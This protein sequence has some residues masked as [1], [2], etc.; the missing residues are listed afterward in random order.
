MMKTLT[1]SF[2]LR[3]DVIVLRGENGG[4][5]GSSAQALTKIGSCR[6]V[7]VHTVLLGHVV[8]GQAAISTGH[9]LQS[10]MIHVQTQTYKHPPRCK[11]NGTGNMKYEYSYLQN[12]ST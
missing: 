12:Y 2:A 7:G 9:L 3:A 10:E 1:C 5:A 8:A 4:H 11:I 6:I